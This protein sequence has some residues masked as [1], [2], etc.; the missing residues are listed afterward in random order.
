ME[1]NSMKKNIF[2]FI[3]ML[4]SA[5]VFSEAKTGTGTVSGEVLDANTA[6]PMFGVTAV[7][8]SIGKSGKTDLDGKFTISGVPDG[9]FDLELIMAGMTPQKRKITIT[10]G[11]APR[12]N[13]VLGQK[14]LDTVIVEGRALN[15]TESSL[16][17]LQKKSSTVSDGISAQAIAKTPD[18]SAG[19]VI[20]RV[21]GI[22]LVGGKF[23]FV[24]GLGE[25]YSN[26]IFN[27]V[28]LPSPEPDK[29]VVPLDLF[30][31]ALL[32]N[33]IVSKTFVPED[34]AEFS[35]GT[36]KIETKE[37]PDQFF[38]K[39]GLTTGYNNNTTF[40]HFKTY[41][42]GNY[43]FPGGSIGKD[44]IGL[45]AGNREKPSI[46]DTVPG[47]PFKEAGQFSFGY[48]ESSITAGSL[49]F[50]NQW[51]PRKMNAPM[52]RGFNFSIGN[53]FKVL[54]ERK[55]GI[56]AAITYGND[57]QYKEE[58]DVFNLVQR[59]APGVPNF[60][61]RNTALKKFNDYRQK[62]WTESVNWGSIFNTTFEIA[63]GQRLHWKNF[64]AV[65]NDKEVREYGGFTAKLPAEIFSQK[66]NFVQRNLFNS[67]IGGDHIIKIKD[68][69][70]KFDWTLSLAEANRNQPDMRDVV[71]SS[72]RNNENAPLLPYTD[73]G[74]NRPT[75]LTNTQSASHFFSSTKD[76]NRYIG[77]NYEIPFSQWQGLQSKLKVG[78][79]ALR[80]E[81]SFEAEFFHFVPRTGSTNR[82]LNG[83]P[84]PDPVYPV[85]GEI[86][87]NPINRGPRGYYITEDTRPTDSYIAKQKL[88]S[89]YG[90]VDMPLIPKLRFIGGARVEN[91]FQSVT[92]FNPFDRFSS[93]TEPYNINSYFYS[94]GPLENG[95]A[96][97]EQ[98]QALLR[99]GGARFVDPNYRRSQVINQKT[100]LLPSSNF[101]FSPTDNQN[102]RVSY[103]QTVS[104]PDF[105]EMSPFEFTP[106]LGGPPVRGNP[107]LKRTYIH[108]YDL[109]YEFYPNKEGE[110]IAVGLFYKNMSS[111]IEKVTEVDQQFRYTYTNAKSAFIQG[112]EFEARKNLG[113][114]S[115]KAER[116]SIGINTFFIKSQVTLNDWLFYQLNSIGSTNTQ[117]PTNLSRPLQGQSPYVYNVNLDYKFDQK[118]DHG[119]TFLYNIFGPRIESVGGLGIPDTYERPVGMFDS[120]YRLKWKEKWE[121][122]IAGRNL[123]DARVKVV[124][125]DPW[126]QKDTTVYSY[127][128]GPTIT[129]SATYNF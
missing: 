44:Q 86:V 63:N 90:Q 79:S 47:T 121:F 114:I 72:Q 57:F 5:Q 120:V 106:I 41:S 26:T 23:V 46:V 8:R 65:N 82:G 55:L 113:F 129:F 54:G 105:R 60:Q 87:Y 21:T 115:E 3:L 40:R 22:T 125:E 12:V 71:W 95:I 37:F 59:V 88:H 25:R 50:N 58:T 15:D 56:I 69:N 38:M 36:V 103:T 102:I 110:V 98:S 78:Y 100:D 81:R 101:V 19:D 48:P 20:R 108:N 68:T 39:A 53:T 127:R 83:N 93:F 4:F 74:N 126:I 34:S 11:K 99:A 31:A 64:F 112:L 62:V 45:D 32:K 33:I 35:G 92:T 14:K 118:G 97:P 27:G 75:I 6:E 52:N 76:V 128:L 67:Q 51:T 9:E 42:E 13:V 70:T 104:R 89:Y 24:R 30:P 16:L 18:S 66:L 119:I 43:D 29:R 91:N 96:T 28:P 10:G 73:L 49:E 84:T 2:I 109:R 77:L 111:P 122:K 94:G 80:R 107:N 123:N 61:N 85:P 17:K 117:A 124:Q 1:I 7:I 116:W